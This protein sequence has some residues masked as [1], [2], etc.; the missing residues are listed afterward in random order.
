[1]AYKVGDTVIHWTHGMGKVIA[2]EEMNLAGIRQTYYKVE[3]GLLMLWIPVEE[4]QQGALR[5]PMAGADFQHLIHILQTPGEPLSDNY[6]KRKY[7]IR[8]R[9]QKR[10]LVDLCHLIRDLSDRSRYHS[11]NQNDADV[12]FRAEEYFLDEW[13]LS[14]GTERSKAQRELDVLL[15]RNFS[16]DAIPS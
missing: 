5:L 4:A 16:D 6:T 11:L 12:L 1:M 15:R 13:V 7:E 2:I 8:D 3:V 10:G 9:M 14:L